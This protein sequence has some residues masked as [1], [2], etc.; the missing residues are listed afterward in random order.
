MLNRCRKNNVDSND[1]LTDG[2]LNRRRTNA[3]NNDMVTDNIFCKNLSEKCI[4]DTQ[5]KNDKATIVINV[6][7]SN[8]DVIIVE[9]D[10]KNRRFLFYDKQKDF[11]GSF[12]IREF[13]KYITAWIDG[14]FIG[15]INS[16]ASEYVIEKYICEVKNTQDNYL[17]DVKLRSYFE[18]PFMGNIEVLI[19]FY[20]FI[21]EYETKYM[22]NDLQGIQE[23]SINR[24]TDVINMVMYVYSSH[25][26]K[27]IA[28]ITSKYCE[29]GDKKIRDSLLQYSVG[30][31]YRL[32]GYVKNEISQ[33]INK[34][35]KLQNDV[36]AVENEKNSILNRL[37]LMQR[38]IDK[39]NICVDMILKHTIM[40]LTGDTHNSSTSLTEIHCCSSTEDINEVSLSQ[41]SLSEI[42]SL[43]NG[44]NKD[45]T[46]LI[47]QS[48]QSNLSER[49]TLRD[50]DNFNVSTHNNTDTI[51][52]M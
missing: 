16:D 41:N 4:E 30:I 46:N 29:S 44:Y 3:G 20:N 52:I 9:T 18:S 40:K 14:K 11:L 28:T 50:D 26:L 51:I 2:M 48:A 15:D 47:N 10:Y 25:M 7:Q 6:Q 1:T 17:P 32:S 12:T 35:N 39:Q 22:T 13:I 24:I 45:G 27:I 31:M 49:T 37:D 8:A 5:Q 42:L 33:K 34:F 23:T 43:H 36:V 19:K 21:H 38:S